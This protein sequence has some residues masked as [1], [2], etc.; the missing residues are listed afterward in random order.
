MHWYS[1]SS[2]RFR[3]YSGSYSTSQIML[4][5]SGNSVRG[6]LYATNSN[7]IGLLDAGGSWA[8]RHANLSLIHI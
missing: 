4:T 8:I 1:D 2:S 5:T 7:E 6:Y 3:L